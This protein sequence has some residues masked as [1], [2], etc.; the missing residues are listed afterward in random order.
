MK[1]F[2]TL[3][4]L[5]QA[6][7]CTTVPVKNEKVVTASSDNGHICRGKLMA[8]TNPLKEQMII[9]YRVDGDGK[10][11]QAAVNCAKTTITDPERRKLYLDTFKG[12]TF[13]NTPSGKTLSI[14]YP[15]APVSN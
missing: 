3:L 12:W 5:F 1:R 7:G 6:L 15:L 14:A 9:N 8:K 11:T 13:K 2:L 4:F 10:V